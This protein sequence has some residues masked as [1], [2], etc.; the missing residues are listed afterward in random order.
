MR[1]TKLCFLKV[2]PRDEL[3][4]AWLSQPVLLVHSALS[5]PPRGSYVANID[6]LH[7][8]RRTRERHEPCELGALLP[9][10]V[11]GDGG[12]GAPAAVLVVLLAVGASGGAAVRAGRGGL[13]LDAGR[14]AA[15]RRLGVVSFGFAVGGGRVGGG[16]APGI[17][18][19]AAKGPGVEAGGGTTYTRSAPTSAKSLTDIEI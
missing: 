11:G 12:R 10:G 5:L 1:L 8:H 13:L 17:G 2:C 15:I 3:L 7:T 18:L 16:A 9:G 14:I 6:F 19:Q 4:S